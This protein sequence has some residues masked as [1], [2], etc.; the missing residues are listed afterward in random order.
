MAWLR[1][2]TGVIL[3]LLEY[4]SSSI[5]VNLG[6]EKCTSKLAR[7]TK[8]FNR[9]TWL[10]HAHLQVDC[11]SVEL[12]TGFGFGFDLD[13]VLYPELG[14]VVLHDQASSPKDN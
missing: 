5:V 4:L 13:R 11:I 3:L 9:S 7:S 8:F 1:S 2:E 10:C 14:L 12:R 6:T